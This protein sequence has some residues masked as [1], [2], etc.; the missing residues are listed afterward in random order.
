[1]NDSDLSAISDDQLFKNWNI[2]LA[3]LYLVWTKLCRENYNPHLANNLFQFLISGVLLNIVGVLGVL[4][5]V[6]SMIILSRPEMKSSFNYLLMGLAR[7]DT[8]L[9]ICIMLVFGIPPIYPYTGRLFWYYNYV[10]AYTAPVMFPIALIAQISSIYMTLIVTVERYVAVCHPLKARALCTYRRI[11][12]YFIVCV[13]FGL[14]F[15]IPRFWEFFT[16]KYQ[17]PSTKIELLCVHASPLR[18]SPSYLKIYRHWCTL[19]INYIIPFLTLAILNSLIYRQVRRANRF[20]KQL[21]SSE[22]HEIGLATILLVAVVAF[23]LLKSVALVMNI[24]DAFY[25]KIYPELINVS[26]LLIIIHSSINFLIYIAL[27]KKY[28]CIFVRIFFKRRVAK[29]DDNLY[30]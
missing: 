29:Q 1:M 7:C 20:R 19:I 8:I 30:L 28:R 5:N 4:G 24:S 6:I 3:D 21:S 22:R 17:V 10:H 27:G 13:C 2:S 12:I 15:N 11:K 23:L 9:I 25:G 16:V 14:I 26:N 18:K